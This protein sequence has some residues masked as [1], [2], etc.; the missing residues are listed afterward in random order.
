[1]RSWAE[2]INQKAEESKRKK[3]YWAA[4]GLC[5]T[6]YRHKLVAQGLIPEEVV[7]LSEEDKNK[8]KRG[9]R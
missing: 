1:M 5:T 9:E 6:E 4:R 8:L 7:P 2:R 3:L